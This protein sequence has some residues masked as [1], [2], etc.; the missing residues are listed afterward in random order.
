MVEIRDIKAAARKIAQAFGPERIILFGSYAYRKPSEDSDVDFLVLVK[1]NRVH[2]DALKI[3]LA[4]DF[5]FPVD[6]LVRSPNEFE[7]RIEMGDCFLREIRDK[8]RILYEAPCRTNRTQ[9]A[10][11]V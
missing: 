8:G 4:V 1:G 3:R 7:R 11:K 9:I 6:I 2:D 5:D 10:I